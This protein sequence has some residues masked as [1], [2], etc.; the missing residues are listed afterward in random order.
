MTVAEGVA[1]GDEL[2]AAFRR[3]GLRGGAGAASSCADEA[4]LDDVIAGPA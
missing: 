1:D 4:D 3:E 2:D